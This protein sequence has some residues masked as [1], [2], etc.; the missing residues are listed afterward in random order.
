MP[1]LPEPIQGY[2]ESPSTGA[3]VPLTALASTALTAVLT[4]T[5]DQTDS[6]VMRVLVLVTTAVT[7]VT[8]YA[9]WTDAGGQPQRWPWLGGNALVP[10]DYALIPMPL[11]A[12]GGTDVTLWVQAGTAGQ[13][14]VAAAIERFV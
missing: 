4:Y 5:A 9:T 2:P 3:K 1:L 6:Y 14:S 10:G 12:Q 13:V 11:S 7:T 8:A